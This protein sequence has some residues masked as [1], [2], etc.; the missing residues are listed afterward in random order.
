MSAAPSSG[1]HRRASK[2]RVRPIEYSHRAV[3]ASESM[4][5]GYSRY[6]GRVGALAVALGVGSAVVSIPIALADTTGSSGSVGS[7]SSDESRAAV[8]TTKSGASSRPQRPP[9]DP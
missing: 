7:G 2:G 5:R 6:V 3:S 9:P 8:A 1:R 4:T